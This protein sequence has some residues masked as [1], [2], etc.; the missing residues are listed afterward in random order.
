MIE[1][2]HLSHQKCKLRT[3]YSHHIPLGKL[4]GKYVRGTIPLRLHA[5]GVPV[6]GILAQVQYLVFKR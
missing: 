2:H 3:I 4:V 1:I 6:K 5:Q